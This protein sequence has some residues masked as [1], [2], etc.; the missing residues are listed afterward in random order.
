MKKKKPT[1]RT[2]KPEKFE[3]AIQPPVQNGLCETLGM[4]QGPFGSIGGQY[5]YAGSNGSPEQVSDTTTLFTNLRWYFVSNMRQL[6]SELYVEIGLIQTIVDVPVNDALRGGV[7]IKSKQLDEE[8]IEELK[9]S[10]KRDDDLGTVGKA[11]KWNR[12]FGG[13]GVLVLVDDQDPE[14]PL[15]LSSITQETNLQFR[16]VDMWE[17]FWDK[18]NTEG[19]DPE[20]QSEEFE[21]YDYYAS[22][23][24]K[25]RVMRLKGIEAPSFLRPRLRGWGFSVVEVLVRSINQYLKATDLTFEVLDEFKIDVYKIKN[26]V[27][28]LLTP[29]GAASVRQRV[30]LANWQKNYQNAVV[31]DSE[32]DWDHKQLSFGGLA[33]AQ[34]GIRKQVCSD[35]R[36]PATKLFGSS[37]NGGLGNADQN[38]MEN[39]N[40]MVE[41]EVRDKSE[42]LV[43]RII[44]IKCQKLFGFIPDDLEVEFNPLRV[45]SSLDEETVKT[46]KFTRLLQA[47]QAG[48]ITTEEFRDACN[49][50]NLF[51]VKLDTTTIGLD[52]NSVKEKGHNAKD[53]KDTV[54]PGTNREDS[55]TPRATRE[56][57]AKTGS[58]LNS[59]AIP[60]RFNSAEFDRKSYEADGGDSWIDPKRAPIFEDPKL[61]D[62]GIWAKAKERTRGGSWQYTVWMYK[63]LGGKV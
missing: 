44:E 35:L 3:N 11:L 10:M 37:E 23:V 50:G 21:F 61:V 57:D 63:K 36:M 26:L 47:K 43:L 27:N 60:P 25:S 58:K 56:L 7:K 41:G 53:V 9:I 16:A 24:H 49:K 52:D 12:L 5:G 39:Y 46:S 18:Q 42:F 34:A 48:E 22:K 31:M 15:D 62:Q 59:K 54:D 2:E 13:A 6:V 38:D 45:L 40:S 1:T 17:L 14:T 28:S 55:R 19:Y 4:S 29:Q 33:E 8:Q 20:I 32:D 51:D 30:Q